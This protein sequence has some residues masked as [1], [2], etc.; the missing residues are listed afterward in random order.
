MTNIVHL[1]LLCL[2]LFVLRPLSNNLCRRYLPF[3][4][5]FADSAAVVKDLADVYRLQMFDVTILVQ[6]L[7]VA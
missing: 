5:F 1:S 2:Y 3:L 6:E 4:C 7:S